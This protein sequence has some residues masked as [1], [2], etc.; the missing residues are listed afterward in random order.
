MAVSRPILAIALVAVLAVPGASAEWLQDQHDATRAGVAEGNVPQ[1]PDIARLV[2]VQWDGLDWKP[3]SLRMVGHDLYFLGNNPTT[4]GC[5]NEVFRLRLADSNLTGLVCIPEQTLDLFSDG[6]H[7]YVHAYDGTIGES[8]RSFGLDGH[9]IWTSAYLNPAVVT[10]AQRGTG[11]VFCLQDLLVETRIYSACYVGGSTSAS[12]VIIATTT[13]G[14]QL[15]VAPINSL[16]TDAPELGTNP[17][18]DEGVLLNDALQ[19]SQAAIPGRNFVPVHLAAS[20]GTLVVTVFVSEHAVD[21]A[22]YAG[23]VLVALDGLDG[24]TNPNTAW[25]YW[26]PLRFVGGIFDYPPSAVMAGGRTVAI[27]QDNQQT[28]GEVMDASGRA[29]VQDWTDIAPG[30]PKAL[31]V[32]GNK[33]YATL[34]DHVV[35]YTIPASGSTASLPVVWGADFPPGEASGR[36]L[37]IANQ[38]ILATSHSLDGSLHAFDAASG[39]RRWS[40]RGLGNPIVSDGFLFATKGTNIAIMGDLPGLMHADGTFSTTYPAPGQPLDVDLS[41]TSPG[42]GGAAKDL[43]VDWGDGSISDWQPGTSASHVYGVGGA[44]TA[45]FQVRN[46]AGQT[47]T[48]THMFCVGCP[49]PSETFL[50][51]AFNTDNQNTTFFIIGLLV[52]ALAGF[53]GV[54]KVA[55]RRSRLRTEIKA[56]EKDFEKL[57]GNPAQCEIMLSERRALAHRLALEAKLDEGHTAI[58]VQRITDLRH[59]LRIG[60]LDRRLN[61]LPYGIVQALQEYLRDG[62]LSLWER[63]HLVRVL[64][65][66]RILSATQKGEVRKLIDGW[67][68][69][70]AQHAEKA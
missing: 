9:L 20:N 32:T 22:S 53:F 51:R 18:D 14:N 50:Q 59:K 63:D 17:V 42:E 11:S 10:Q 4:K 13:D 56:L 27:S 7:L 55:R 31:A 35:A 45:R 16:L 66:D 70:D 8:L 54:L 57:H 62:M 12:G 39:H 47:S 36:E 60:Q 5:E 19:R 48:L 46:S 1:W 64:D 68:E 24:P 40:E 61:F 41:A 44:V 15:W 25:T 30:L 23:T 58:L 52:T 69:Q 37:V 67:F 21:Q 33:A 65:E 49:D 6:Q 38:T 34:G 43:W 3:N 28:T 29:M 26:N 2:P